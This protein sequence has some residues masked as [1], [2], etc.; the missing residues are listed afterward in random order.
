MNELRN[1]YDNNAM[2]LDAIIEKLLIVQYGLMEQISTADELPESMISERGYDIL[3][4]K[5]LPDREGLVVEC[6]EALL[7]IPGEVEDWVDEDLHNDVFAGAR[8]PHDAKQLILK[9]RKKLER[10][11]PG[12]IEA[13]GEVK[14]ER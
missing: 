11:R 12:I 1:K 3:F 4:D 9:I 8:C 13:Y 2:S 7:N 5:Y 6:L 10:N 14:D